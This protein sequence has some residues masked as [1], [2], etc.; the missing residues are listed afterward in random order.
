MTFRVGQRVVCV[1]VLPAVG[2]YAH[3]AP[4]KGTIY[5]VAGWEW[6]DVAMEEIGAGI[7]WHPSQFR[8]LQTISQADDIAMFKELVETMKP[9]ER[10]DA[11][12]ELLD[13]TPS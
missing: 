4:V 1:M 7:Y 12:R 11:L 10:L 13:T 8:P 3:K 2:T 6:G 5:T 9:T